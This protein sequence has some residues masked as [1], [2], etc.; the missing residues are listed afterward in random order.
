MELCDDSVLC[1]I[2]SHDLK[3][4]WA[5]RIPRGIAAEVQEVMDRH[6]TRQFDIK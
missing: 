1:H 5:P 6:E 4:S 3:I 2:L